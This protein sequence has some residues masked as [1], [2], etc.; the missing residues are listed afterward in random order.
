MVTKSVFIMSNL[1]MIRGLTVVAILLK[2]IDMLGFVVIML[3][4]ENVTNFANK[5][6]VQLAKK[7]YQNVGTPLFISLNILVRAKT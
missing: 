4:T 5:L 7:S 6:L 1:L 2:N 3:K